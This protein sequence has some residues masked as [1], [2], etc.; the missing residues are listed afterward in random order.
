[1]YNVLSKGSIDC[2]FRNLEDDHDDPRV[3]VFSKIQK[4]HGYDKQSNRNRFEREYK[5]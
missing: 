1:M 3:N 4:S 5:F 2:E